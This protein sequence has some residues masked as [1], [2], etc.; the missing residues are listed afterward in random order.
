MWL[1]TLA[2]SHDAKAGKGLEDAKAV[3]QGK[4]SKL[5]A[6]AELGEMSERPGAWMPGSNP[7]YVKTAHSRGTTTRLFVDGKRLSTTVENKKGEVTSSDFLV[8]HT[9]RRI[10]T[11]KT[12]RLAPVG[13]GE[14]PGD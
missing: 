11:Q 1:F 7:V 9:Q 14:R 4:P 12:K 2:T 13:K 8:S 5:G 10:Q 6:K 3:M